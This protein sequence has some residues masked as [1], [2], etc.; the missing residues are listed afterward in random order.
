MGRSCDSMERLTALSVLLVSL[1]A[2]VSAHDEIG[3]A[4]S[5]GDGATSA[6]PLGDLKPAAGG[7]QELRGYLHLEKSERMYY[8]DQSECAQHCDDDPKCQSYSWNQAKKDC[9]ISKTAIRY[10][11]DYDYY[12]RLP[13]GGKQNGE[14]FGNVV[15]DYSVFTG[16]KYPQKA[17]FVERPL[18]TFEKCKG[19]CDAEVPQNYVNVEKRSIFNP[20]EKGYTE[21][22]GCAAFSYSV[23]KSDCL[24]K[25]EPVSITPHYNYFVKRSIEQLVGGESPVEDNESNN[26][27]K[28]A[29]NADQKMARAKTTKEKN[30]KQK[31]AGEVEAEQDEIKQQAE[32]TAKISV[33][34]ETNKKTAKKAANPGAKKANKETEVKEKTQKDLDKELRLEQARARKKERGLKEVVA[35]AKRKEDLESGIKLAAKSKEMKEK[36]LERKLK[37]N[38]LSLLNEVIDKAQL[39]AHSERGL[40]AAQLAAKEYNSK[41]VL[42]KQKVREANVQAK[43]QDQS[44]F[45]KMKKSEATADR[46]EAG[47][48]TKIVGEDKKAQGNAKNEAQKAKAI[49]SSTK[50]KL[51]ESMQNLGKLNEKKTKLKAAGKAN[52]LKST[53]DEIIKE[54]QTKKELEGTV[55]SEQAVVN[56]AE[57]NAKAAAD[58][59][60]NA[61]TKVTGDN[62][63]SNAKYVLVGNRPHE[64]S[65]EDSTL[66]RK[67]AKEVGLPLPGE[68]ILNQPMPESSEEMAEDVESS[69]AESSAQTEQTEEDAAK[70]IAQQDKKEE[71]KKEEVKEV[72]EEAKDAATKEV[73]GLRESSL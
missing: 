52:E 27:L 32:Q 4:I 3:H 39:I 33:Q 54:E 10:D 64:A 47:Q 8:V 61:E 22:D 20:D 38:L 58:T 46:A 71:Q 24:L 65:F 28:K 72:K 40:K 68:D 41:E 14:A 35:K 48:D 70:K 44:Q 19:M 37:G 16:M 62:A 26:Q 73:V 23:K 6:E 49:Q 67:F 29:E 9:V 50:Q 36:G 12:S 5:L 31:V 2:L 60:A 30:D 51:A 56:Q 15:G 11:Q 53:R 7:Y 63:A 45:D 18:T 66:Y 57:G 43:G 21:G 17:K 59:T 25:G 69:A 34:E 42:V 1:T 55:K 13:E